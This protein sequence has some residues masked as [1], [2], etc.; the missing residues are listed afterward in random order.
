MPAAAA[1]PATCT[2]C[3]TVAPMHTM[4]MNDQGALTCGSCLAQAESQAGMRKRTKNIMLAP[5]MVSVLAYLSFLI[6]LV[7]LAAPGI[8]AAIALWSAIGG[9]RLYNELG[10]RRDNEGVS[11]GLRTGLLVMSILTIIFASIPLLLQILAWI[12]LA[13]A[14]S[15]PRYSNW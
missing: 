1:N 13:L 12:G 8:L 6:P 9:I 7:N 10:H 11:P 15:H 4:L 14:P 5:A 2:A 3:G